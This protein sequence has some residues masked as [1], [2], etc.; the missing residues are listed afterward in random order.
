MGGGPPLVA[1]RQTRGPVRALDRGLASMSSRTSREG[2]RIALEGFLDRRFATI[3]G[4]TG[5]RAGATRLIYTRKI[6]LAAGGSP[7]RRLVSTA[8]GRVGKLGSNVGRAA[9]RARRFR[10][11]SARTSTRIGNPAASCLSR[12]ARD[13]A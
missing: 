4:S 9:A 10:R 11:D 2:H 1:L 8:L 3:G 5:R 7:T 12:P 13:W 6:P